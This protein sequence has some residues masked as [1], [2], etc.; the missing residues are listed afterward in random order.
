MIYIWILGQSTQRIIYII[1]F[2]FYSSI[3]S[4]LQ[5]FSAEAVFTNFCYFVFKTL[6]LSCLQ[7]N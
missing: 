6:I 5:I 1:I 7:N 4:S 3:S 2:I